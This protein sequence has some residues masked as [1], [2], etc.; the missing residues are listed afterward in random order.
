VPHNPA[1]LRA[2]V[3]VG[4]TLVLVLVVAGYAVYAGFRH[5]IT[6]AP[7]APGC[8]A[9]TGGQA[10]TLDT[11]QAAIAATIAGVA[12]RHRL[13]RQ[14]V[15]IALA[16]A[17]QE[18][19]LH[20]LN[21]G[22]RDSVGIFQQRPSQGWGP[23]TRLEDPVYATTRFFAALTRVRG[24]ATMPVS[25]AAQ[26]VQRSADGSAYGQWADLA[27]QLAGYFTGQSPHGVSCWYTPAGQANLTGAVRRMT[28][29]FGPLGQKAVVVRITTDR[30]GQ[31]NKGSTAV[32]HVERAAAWTVASW[33]VAYAQA[34]RLSEVRYA[35]YAWKAANGSMG[36][37][38]DSTPVDPTSAS[39]KTGIVA[40]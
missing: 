29:T 2:R 22:D 23:A 18:S 9:G 5:V 37:Q 6:P 3:I 7:P 38:R 19:K 21:Y 1:V 39:G 35:G 40:G 11:E 27:G 15:T 33:L 14:A 36:W 28:Q 20:N 17:L 31:K 13:P 25:Q 32:L 26:D 10:V 8:Q 16:A 12:A 34:Y 4:T 24:Y 30:S